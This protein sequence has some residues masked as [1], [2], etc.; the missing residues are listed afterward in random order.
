MLIGVGG[1]HDERYEES[2]EYREQYPYS[3][4]KKE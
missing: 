4:V 2:N 3:T 1:S